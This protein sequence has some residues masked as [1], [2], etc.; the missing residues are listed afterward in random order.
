MEMVESKGGGEVT[1]QDDPGVVRG[2]GTGVPFFDY[3]CR[4]ITTTKY[5]YKPSFSSKGF[6]KTMYR[7]RTII[8]RK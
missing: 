4:N 3:K 7:L 2:A 1:G 5:I 8:L 6:K